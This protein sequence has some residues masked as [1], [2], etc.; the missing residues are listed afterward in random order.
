M[1][2]SQGL[3]EDPATPPILEVRD[4]AVTFAGRIGLLSG[5]MGRA[6]SEARAVDGVNLEVRRGEVLALAGESG[7][8][9]TRSR[10]PCS[11]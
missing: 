11:G 10:G 2:G 6:G 5:L 1:T 8:G 7:C 3:S 4:L 9:K